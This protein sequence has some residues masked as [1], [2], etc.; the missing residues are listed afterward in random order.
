MSETT[1]ATP[2]TDDGG[3]ELAELALAATRTAEVQGRVLLYGPPGTGKTTAAVHEARAAGQSLVKVTLTD[4][5][6]MAE[7]RGHWVPAGDGWTWHHGPAIRAWLDGSLLLL[8]EIDHA[9]MDLHSFLQ[10][11]L[12]D[13]DVARITLPNGETVQPSPAFR[14]VATMNGEPMDLPEALLDRFGIR[15]A[16]T[17]PHAAAVAALPERIRG[18][19][20]D[21]SS[22]GD[23]MVRV[24]LRPFKAYGSLLSAGLAPEAAAALTLPERV[25]E[26]VAAAVAI[27]AL[28]M[29]ERADDEPE[30]AELPAHPVADPPEVYRWASAVDDDGD[31]QC[32]SCE[33]YMR[34][35]TL[36]GGRQVE[37]CIHDD[38][39]AH[40]DCPGCGE[41]VEASGAPVR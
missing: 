8:D 12:D 4:G 14:C 37:W 10:G 17:R 29:V 19:A 30:A 7:L 6:P 40:V 2:A 27:G 5:T 32:E 28:P 20:G 38:G 25:R 18:V 1:T 11:L 3:W 13:A 34:G 35:P 31:V 15:Q 24:G 26:D 22:H 33:C 23:P 39:L 21:F 41:M 16:I 36:P 9:A